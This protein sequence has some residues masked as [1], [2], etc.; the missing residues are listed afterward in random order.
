MHA[1]RTEVKTK[2]ITMAKAH[3]AINN[4]KLTFQAPTPQNGQT[5]SSNSWAKVDELLD[6]F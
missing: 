4:Q 3:R 5:Y 2:M 6:Y 1:S